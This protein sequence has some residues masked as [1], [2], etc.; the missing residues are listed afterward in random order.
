MNGLTARLV[1]LR[2]DGKE[3]TRFGHQPKKFALF[4]GILI[5]TV[6]KELSFGLNVKNYYGSLKLN[7]QVEGSV[8]KRPGHDIA[9]RQ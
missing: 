1:Q 7:F 5:T 2:T 8:P 3:E 9:S 6:V 4:L